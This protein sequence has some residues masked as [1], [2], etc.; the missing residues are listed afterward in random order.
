MEAQLNAILADMQGCFGEFYFRR[1][2]D[3]LIMQRRPK[4]TKPPTEKQK[5]WR[6]KFAEQYASSKSRIAHSRKLETE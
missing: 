2:G 3:K 1:C 5:E 4:H 6:K